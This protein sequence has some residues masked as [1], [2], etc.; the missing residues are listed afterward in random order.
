MD[1]SCK[2]P[3]FLLLRERKKHLLK[4]F[5]V[6]KVSMPCCE[7]RESVALQLTIWLEFASFCLPVEVV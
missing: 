6:M 2:N 3:S 7:T 5:P 4:V 1:L